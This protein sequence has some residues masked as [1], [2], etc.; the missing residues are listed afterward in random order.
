MESL[1]CFWSN[2]K[3]YATA[4]PGWTI[5]W[6]YSWF[7]FL[8]QTPCRNRSSWNW[9]FSEL[10]WT[11]SEGQIDVCDQSV[12]WCWKL[13]MRSSNASQIAKVGQWTKLRE[14]VSSDDMMEV[15]NGFGAAHWLYEKLRGLE[16]K[17]SILSALRNSG[18]W[19][20]VF[21]GKPKLGSIRIFFSW[22]FVFKS[23][24]NFCDRF[25]LIAR[26]WLD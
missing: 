24:P 3:K 13:F 21:F 15:C 7:F 16:P 25:G 2:Y 12:W 18:D 20:N 11:R 4:V 23:W 10:F 17:T 14:F 5:C 6:E 19:V 1:K 9:C 22:V 8:A 26:K